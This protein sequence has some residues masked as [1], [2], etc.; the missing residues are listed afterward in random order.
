MTLSSV[1]NI[2]GV[3]QQLQM[4]FDPYT[5]LKNYI[6]YIDWVKFEREADKFIGAKRAKNILGSD[7]AGEGGG[8]GF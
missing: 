6:P 2:A 5:F 7:G 3:F 4:E 1:G 8:G